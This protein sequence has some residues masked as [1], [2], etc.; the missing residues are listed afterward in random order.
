VKPAVGVLDP[1]SFRDPDSRVFYE[2]GAVYRVLSERGLREWEAFAASPLSG[3]LAGEGKL[4]ATERVGPERLPGLAASDAAVLHHERI[5]FVSYPYEWPFGMLKAAALLQLELLERALVDGFTMKDASPYNVHWVGVRPVFADVG[6]FERYVDGEPWAAYR[7][8]CMLFLYPLLLQAYRGI[9]FQPWLRGSLEGISPDECARLLSSRD[10]LRSGVL[11]HVVAHRSLERRYARA[12]RGGGSVK[13]ELRAA[14]FS[15]E[16]ILANVRRLGRLIRRLDWS[17]GETTWSVYTPTTSYSEA[18]AGRKLAF[19][20]R[21]VASRGWRLAWDVG[22]GEG[23]FTRIAA[24]H[25][26]YTVALDADRLVVERLYRALRDEQATGILPLCVNMADPSP[27]LGW[28]CRER[29]GLLERGAPDLVLCLAVVHHL[30][31]AGNVPLEEVVD[32]LRS[33]DAT[34]VVEFP[35]RGDS[36]VREML[37]AKPS[38][39]HDDYRRDWF[40]RCLGER[41]RID[42]TEELAGGNRVLYVC[43][44][45]E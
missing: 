10:R 16:L 29:Q 30:A 36:M 20:D 12:G 41:F 23:H 33:L 22:A 4:V 32:W 28:R 14:G 8:F 31:I 1:G 5:P 18:D 40:E 2:S 3:A 42:A 15:H 43:R 39:T 13:R 27:G 34:L 9:A 6:S 7:Q 26:R 25:A 35:T 44:P 38:A 45:A 11:T 37:D 17:P 19:V 21:A 24:R